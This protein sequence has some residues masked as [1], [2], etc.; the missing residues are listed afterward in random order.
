MDRTQRADYVLE[1]ASFGMQPPAQSERSVLPHRVERGA[2]PGTQDL[3]ARRI[4]VG[5]IKGTGLKVGS[6]LYKNFQKLGCVQAQVLC[7]PDGEALGSGFVEFVSSMNAERALATSTLSIDGQILSLERFVPKMLDTG[8]GQV[9]SSSATSDPEGEQK[10]IV[11]GLSDS[12][13]YLSVRRHFERHGEVI[14]AYVQGNIGFIHYASKAAA[15]EALARPH[16]LEGA[17]LTVNRMPDQKIQDRDFSRK[18]GAARG[19]GGQQRMVLFVGGLPRNCTEAMLEAHFS[20]F[21]PLK[22]NCVK[23]HPQTGRPRGFGFIEFVDTSHA[24]EVLRRRGEHIIGGRCVG[25]EKVDPDSRNRDD[26][27]RVSR[28]NPY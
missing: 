14:Q 17:R 15:Q 1:Y 26:S 7:S 22:Q 27:K 4:A 18:G 9:A 24:R 11:S 2:C 16:D 6:L 28:L 19:S 5:G 23:M 21:G 10:L 13:T 25:I 12:S 20:Q 8:V 3:H